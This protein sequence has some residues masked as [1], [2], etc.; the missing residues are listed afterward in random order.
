MSIDKPNDQIRDQIRPRQ[1]R[2]DGDDHHF[3]LFLR[4]AA[5]KV[6]EV[7][8]IPFLEEKAKLRQ[9]RVE[10]RSYPLFLTMFVIGRKDN[11]CYHA[12]GLAYLSFLRASTIRRTICCPNKTTSSPTGCL[13]I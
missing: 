2:Q 8:I 12:F 9:S 6:F 3:P 5:E 4:L 7:A 1:H 10:Y 13:Q 11:K